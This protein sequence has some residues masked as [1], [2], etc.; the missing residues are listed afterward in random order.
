[1]EAAKRYKSD[2]ELLRLINNQYAIQG[3]RI[4]LYRALM[5]RV[6]F[7]QTPSGRKVFKLY[8][9]TVTDAAIQTTRIISYLDSCGYPII[10]IVPTVSGELYVTVDRPEGICIGVL[11][12]YASGICI[13]TLEKGDGWVMNPL[14]KELSRSVGC[15]HRLMERHNKPLI[16]RGAEYYFDCL[17]LLLRWDNYDEAKIRDFEEYGNK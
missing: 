5:G 16:R 15:M 3:E 13:W 12:E 2:N 8:R 10:K 7:I 1:M 6:F 4:R 17:V 14:T 11:F 9:P